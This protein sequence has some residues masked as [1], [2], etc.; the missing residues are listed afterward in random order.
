MAKNIGLCKTNV[1]ISIF[2]Q[3]SD[4]LKL[5]ARNL[6]ECDGKLFAKD[7]FFSRK[8]VLCE[9]IGISWNFR[10]FWCSIPLIASFSLSENFLSWKLLSK[11]INYYETDVKLPYH[12][13]QFNFHGHKAKPKNYNANK[14]RSNRNKFQINTSIYPLW[15]RKPKRVAH[16]NIVHKLHISMY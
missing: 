7:F 10:R 4:F 6:Q 3:M 16:L 2:M 14:L 1:W 12:N 15:T 5:L 9:L 11:P 13:H 8:T